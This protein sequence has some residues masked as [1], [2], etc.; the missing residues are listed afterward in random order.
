MRRY[1][2]MIRTYITNG[3]I[4]IALFM[5]GVYTFN[6]FPLP[7]IGIL[8][9]IIYPFIILICYLERFFDEI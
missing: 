2:I 1:E 3:L 5:I 4:C 6:N 9:A 8:I 7:F